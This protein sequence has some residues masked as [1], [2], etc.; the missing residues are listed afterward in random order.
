[1][2]KDKKT[3]RKEQFKLKRLA[4]I[5]ASQGIRILVKEGVYNNVNEGL[6]EMY[7]EE[8]PDIEEF[9]TFN[10]WKEQGYTINKGSKAF[11]IWGQ[12]R[13]A[14]QTPEGSEEHE[15]FK[16][17]PICYLFSN[18]QYQN[19]SN[20]YMR[21]QSLKNLYYKILG[22]CTTG[23]YFFASFFEVKA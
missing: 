22:T 17:W 11:I 9:N 16:Y 23:G 10:Q 1:M 4:L 14:E 15:E 6:L 8:N 7:T 18:T 12:P 19:H 2:S 3:D 20:K 13:K 21:L 5:A